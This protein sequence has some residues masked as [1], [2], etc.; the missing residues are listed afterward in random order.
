VRMSEILAIWAAQKQ[1]SEDKNGSM[2]VVLLLL[3]KTKIST[4]CFPFVN[5]GTSPDRT[6]QS[7][8]GGIF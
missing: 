7:F 2:R 3:M 4:I 8:S 6:A 1:L 5:I